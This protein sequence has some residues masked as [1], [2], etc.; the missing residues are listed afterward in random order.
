MAKSLWEQMGRKTGSE[1]KENKPKKKSEG[2]WSK[3]KKSFEGP[4]ASEAATEFA[5]R[6]KKGSK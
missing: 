4:S 3:L 5:K 1:D 2:M 6:M